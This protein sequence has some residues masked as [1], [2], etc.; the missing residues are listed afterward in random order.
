MVILFGPPGAGKSVQGQIMAA[1]H[2]WRWLSTGQ[3]LRDSHD[4]ALHQVM[5][6]GELVSDEDINR[7]IAKAIKNG[8]GIDGIILDGFPRNR[9][10]A[11]WLVSNLDEFER[12][13]IAVV[14]LE[15]TDDE[16]HKR[17]NIRGRSDDTPENVAKRNKEYHEKTEPVIDFFK[18]KSFCVHRVDGEGS[19]GTVHDRIEEAI[20]ECSHK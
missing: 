2:G 13:V 19:V 12:Q 5:T 18:Q 9:Q 16:I 11:E 20:Q 7:I 3:L 14:S 8:K 4:E 6:S 10:Q 17:L 1:R 15:V